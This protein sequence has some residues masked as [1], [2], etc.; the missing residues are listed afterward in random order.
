MSILGELLDALPKPKEKTVSLLDALPDPNVPTHAV[1]YESKPSLLETNI[2]SMSA[3]EQFAVLM[4]SKEEGKDGGPGTT[5]RPNKKRKAGE[6]VIPR[7]KR[8]RRIR[9]R[10]IK[11]RTRGNQRGK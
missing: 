1:D 2:L 10:E 6:V 8:E 4:H 7:K 3:A 11:Q 5:S 9:G